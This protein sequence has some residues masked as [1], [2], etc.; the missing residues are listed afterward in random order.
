M[1]IILFCCMNGKASQS[2]MAAVSKTVERH[3]LEGSTPSLSAIFAGR[4][5]SKT[6]AAIVVS[7]G[8]GQNMLLPARVQVA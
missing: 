2:A 1:A 8:H 4:T 7:S 6:S 5:N 3:S